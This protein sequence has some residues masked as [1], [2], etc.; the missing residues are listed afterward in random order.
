MAFFKTKQEKQIMAQMERDEQMEVF[1]NQINELK[2]KREEYAKIAAEAEVNNDEG[3]YNIAV[4]NL[5]ELNDVISSLMQTKA[6]FD[7]INVSNSIAVN[8]AMAVNALSNMASGENK[9]PNLKKVQ[10]VNV[11]VAKYM[12][13]I[14][15]SN[16]AMSNMM[17]STNPANR[18]RS[19]A[20]IASVKPMI[21]AYRAK[22]TN[23]SMPTNNLDLSAEIEAERN[24]II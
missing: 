1:N 5:I 23:V 10:K 3:T 8:M 9:M 14:K 22:L 4:N 19:D 21:D 11:K 24:R 15:I 7:I 13:Q 16:K 12:K 20:E 2:T 18:A 17:K 6:N